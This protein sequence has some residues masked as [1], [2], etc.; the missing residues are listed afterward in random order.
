MF[1][2]APWTKVKREQDDSENL[3]S[4]SVWPVVNHESTGHGDLYRNEEEAVREA[5][6]VFLDGSG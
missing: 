1:A 4:P 2:I 5:S 6:D 3:P